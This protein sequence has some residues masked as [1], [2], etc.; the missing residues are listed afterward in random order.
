MRY[1]YFVLQTR[2]QA[3]GS[4]PEVDGI[5]EN[6]TTGERR[7]FR[8]LDDVARL[9]G[10]WAMAAGPVAEDARGNTE[11]E[12]DRATSVTCESNGGVQT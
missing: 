2:S 3:D 1:G 4:Q 5:V 7:D 9:I 10:A 6:L 8:S 12:G 11:A